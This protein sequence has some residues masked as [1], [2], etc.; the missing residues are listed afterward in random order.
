MNNIN[1]NIVVESDGW[2]DSIPQHNDLVNKSVDNMC[3][4]ID[5]PEILRDKKN[6][7]NIILTN[8]KNMRIL[9]EDFRNQDK[10]TNV[11]SFALIDDENIMQVIE[12][13]EEYNE[14]IP[15]GDVIIA[16]ETIEREAKEQNKDLNH[17][18]QHIL[19][20]G[21]LHIMGYDHINEED[22]LIMEEVEVK[23][24]SNLNIA[25]PYG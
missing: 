24:L 7:I 19:I 2:K 8:D 10:S 11:L 14:N 15:A 18:F 22:A 6:E 5:T 23:L 16:L 21:I 1:Y 4:Y 25:N 13:C 9:N 20:H 3:K 17:H 12:Q